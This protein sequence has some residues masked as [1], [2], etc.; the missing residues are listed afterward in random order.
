MHEN[1][2]FAEGGVAGSLLFDPGAP[3]RGIVLQ[4]TPAW[5]TATAGGGVFRRPDG[6]L[7]LLPS[8]ANRANL[9]TCLS[10]GGG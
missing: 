5:A 4:V 6:G 3:G 1:D 8:G 7:P 9:A 2:G 10:A